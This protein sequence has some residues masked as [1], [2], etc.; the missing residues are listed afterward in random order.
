MHETLPSGPLKREGVPNRIGCNNKLARAAIVC[1]ALLTGRARAHFPFHRYPLS[2]LVVH[3]GIRLCFRLDVMPD[4]P[5][6]G[7]GGG[8]PGAEA[9]VLD[10]APRSSCY[11]LYTTWGIRLYAF[12]G[13]RLSDGGVHSF[14]DKRTNQE[15]HGW[16]EKG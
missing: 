7:S 13:S 3:P 12:E 15:N 1:N 14:L 6:R 8:H 10:C 16:E 2:E 11:G 5:R 9:A 4:R